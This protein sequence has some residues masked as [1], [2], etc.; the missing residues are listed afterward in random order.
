MEM[1]P[2]AIVGTVSPRVQRRPASVLQYSS[3]YSTVQTT[4]SVGVSVSPT[5][6]TMRAGGVL[7]QVKYGLEN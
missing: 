5:V 2:A 1:V 6:Q 3:N 4:N 7:V